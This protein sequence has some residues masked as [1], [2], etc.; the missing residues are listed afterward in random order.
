M[1]RSTNGWTLLMAVP[2]LTQVAVAQAASCED[3]S[4]QIEAFYN[5]TVDSCPGNNGEVQAACNC[6]G[7]IARGTKRPEDN[8]GKAGDYYVWQ[9]SPKS[10]EHR[11]RLIACTPSCTTNTRMT[12]NGGSMRR[13]SDPC[14]SSCAISPTKAPGRKPGGILNRH[15]LTSVMKRR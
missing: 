4:Q 2:F 6:S 5:K 8:G 3:T 13:T 14:G 9:T 10:R 7:L 12:R 1:K 11:I 15:V